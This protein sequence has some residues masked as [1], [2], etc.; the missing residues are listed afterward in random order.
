MTVTE[1]A[2]E[3]WEREREKELL[4]WAWRQPL[5]NWAPARAFVLFFAAIQQAKINNARGRIRVERG[6]LPPATLGQIS[7]GK[8]GSQLARGWSECA[9]EKCSLPLASFECTAGRRRCRRRRRDSRWANQRERRRSPPPAGTIFI[10]LSRRRCNL[11]A[12]ARTL[13]LGCEWPGLQCHR[14]D[15]PLPELPS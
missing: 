7:A 12:T 14:T 3:R 5:N 13:S 10:A 1:P 6:R 8:N 9:R 15:V 4:G 11:F 2:S